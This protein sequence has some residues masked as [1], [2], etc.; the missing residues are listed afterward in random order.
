MHE[1]SADTAHRRAYDAFL[2]DAFESP[3]AVA[4]YTVGPRQFVPG[5][6]AL[7]RMTAILLAERAPSDARIL[8]LGAGG[9]LELKALAE[10]HP[11]W[12]FTGV[13][14]STEMLK[15]ARQNLGPLAERVDLIDGY[16]DAA[17]DGPFDGAVCLLTL[18]FLDATE[19]R[20]TVYKIRSRLRS[21]A[22]FVAAHNTLP[23]E[24]ASR[25]RALTRYAAYAVASG[26]DPEQTE[27]RRAGIDAFP[28][29]LPADRDGEIL[30]DAGYSDVSP[31]YAA[32]SWRGWIA[33]A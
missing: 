13:D 6:D 25:A 33:Y 30:S 4:N 3:L 21:G 31:F 20:E 12:T 23:S 29:M 16:I 15:L 1:T 24:P 5:L 22:P 8:V 10:A 18:H 28:A 26:A 27:Q 11:R 7:H 19:R 2:G 32:F 17:P 9:G 14:P